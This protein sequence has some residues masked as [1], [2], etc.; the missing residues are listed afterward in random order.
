[1]GYSFTLERVYLSKEYSRPAPSRMRVIGTLLDSAFQRPQRDG[2]FRD[3]LD[4]LSAT[5]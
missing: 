1:M 5:R 4:R 3:L 2:D